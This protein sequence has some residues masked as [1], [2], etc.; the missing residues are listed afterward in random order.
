MTHHRERGGIRWDRALTATLITWFLA[1]SLQRL[2]VLAQAPFTDIRLYLRG[3]AAWLRGDDPWSVHIGTVP[4]AAAPPSLLPM[5][6]FT[7]LP[8]DVA[9]LVL[10]VLGIGASL[11]TIRRLGLPWWFMAWPPLVDNL[12]NG[13]PQI[14]LV[15]LLLGSW[16]WLAP[17][18]KVYAVVPLVLGLRLRALAIAALVVLAT[19]PL[20]PWD[21]FLG[22]L[23]STA[24]V[25]SEQSQGGMSA[26]A[27]APLVPIGI[28]A[29][30]LM[31]RRHSRWWFLP[32]LWP[33][34]Q[35]YYSL[36]AMPAMGPLAA[37][38]LAAPVQGAPVLAACV[39]VL[40]LRLPQ[41]WPSIRARLPRRRQVR[42][43]L[44]SR[45]SP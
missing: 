36:M 18:L 26:W 16:A 1:L 17:I 33:S 35:W 20:L 10:L 28:V 8:E 34:T 29:L 30:L 25:L 39:A 44:G 12:A 31:P 24:S 11:W 6:P 23:G 40:E 43:T 27:F 45:G 7:L 37:A 42:P 9:V 14:F 22:R 19:A 32:V 2:S 21:T 15:P 3:S 38:V 5:A 41:H 13:N 4:Y